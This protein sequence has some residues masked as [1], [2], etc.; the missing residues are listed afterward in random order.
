M[1][2][3]GINPQRGALG[4]WVFS[5]E[6]VLLLVVVV[7]VWVHGS[8]ACCQFGNVCML[9]A[10]SCCVRACGIYHHVQVL[11]VCVCVHVG[12][13]CSCHVR[14]ALLT[15]VVGQG[16]IYVWRH[17][18]HPACFPAECLTMC[19]RS[20]VLEWLVAPQRGFCGS[21]AWAEGTLP[22]VLNGAGVWRQSLLSWPLC[23]D[24]EGVS[25]CVLSCA[26]MHLPAIATSCT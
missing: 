13:S 15:H 25:G 22:P 21:R 11:C 6:G 14:I 23:G 26:C 19:F 16:G 2:V 5:G 1:A 4:V 3:A 17:S 12:I 10:D 7:L 9:T 8:R 20:L 18:F 24:V